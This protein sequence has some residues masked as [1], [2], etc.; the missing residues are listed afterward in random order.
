MRRRSKSEPAQ[1]SLSNVIHR[2]LFVDPSFHTVTTYSK[3]C[4]SDRNEIRT[5]RTV[6]MGSLLQ[7]PAAAAIHSPSLHQSQAP[8]VRRPSSKI[9][10]HLFSHLPHR[11]S[12][13]ASLASSHWR[14]T[15]VEVTRLSLQCRL[16]MAGSR[17]CVAVTSQTC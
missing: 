8:S 15:L 17:F 11:I 6:L 16:F 4:S 2:R 3:I 14:P 9:N 13:G 7:R 1:C 10:L 5:A 12:L